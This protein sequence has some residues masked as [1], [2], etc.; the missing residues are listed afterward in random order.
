AK[1]RKS[2]GLRPGIIELV[3]RVNEEQ[4]L[5]PV[6][7]LKTL[8]PTLKGKKIAI[9]GLAF[10]PGT[11]DMRDAPSLTVVRELQKAGARIQAFDPVA[12]ARAR[13]LLKQV[14]FSNDPYRTLMGCDA[15]LILTE[16]DEFRGL[17]KKRIKALLKEP[18]VVDGRNVYDPEE[19]QRL[20]FKYLG[21]GRG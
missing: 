19:V 20:G 9:W 11:D 12:E 13:T 18:N 14:S 1:M 6:K 16:W 7:K 17:D 5:L 15:L 10:K 3:D 21:I 2:Y 4:K 8:L